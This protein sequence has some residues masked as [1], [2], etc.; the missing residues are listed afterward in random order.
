MILP[1]IIFW[2][3]HLCVLE[4]LVQIKIRTL[5]LAALLIISLMKTYIYKNDIFDCHTIYNSHA[6]VRNIIHDL[7]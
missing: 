6:H 1:R 4:S 3:N 7:K 2:G 5:T